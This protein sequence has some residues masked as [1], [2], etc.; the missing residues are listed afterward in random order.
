MN[1][2][3]ITIRPACLADAPTITVYNLRMAHETEDLRLNPS[4]VEQGVRAVFE[5]DRRGN[6]FVAERAGAVIACLLVT[7]E[8]SDWRNGDIWWIQ[9]VYVHP[10]HRR[11]G[12]F[13]T[14]FAEAE[15]LARAQGAVAMRLYVER[16]NADA[17]RT[18]ESLGMTRA[19]Y[20]IMHRSLLPE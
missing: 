7:H 20:D 9:S 14:L 3:P 8:W 4:T 16:D 15:R 12:V 11:Q 10:E 17:G 6:Y 2:P 13:R 18:Y 19:S 5:D 1:Q